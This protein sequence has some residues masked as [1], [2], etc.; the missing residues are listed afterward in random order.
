MMTTGLIK[1]IQTLFNEVIKYSQGIENPI[2]DDVFKNWA[3]NKAHFIEKWGGLRKELPEVV[4]LDR[5]EEDKRIMF[6]DFIFD[7]T[8]FCYEKKDLIK[9]F[10]ED[11]G[12]EGFY[13]NRVIKALDEDGIKIPKGAK[14]SKALKVF[15]DDKVIL[16][17][18]QTRMSRL[19][20]DCKITGKFVMSVHPLDFLS[21]SETAH[22]WHSCHSLD[23]E[24]RTGNLSYM[25][26][27]HTFMFY[28]KAEEDCK[29]PNFP[30]EWNSKKWRMLMYMSKDEQVFVRGRQYPFSN[31]RAVELATDMLKKYYNLDNF[32]EWTDVKSR[33]NNLM[34]DDIG[35][36]QYNDCLCSPSYSPMAIYNKDKEDDTHIRTNKSR[37]RVGEAV[38]CLECGRHMI[39]Y[40][41]SM[42]CDECAGY[43]Y[44]ECCGEACY[45]D[46]MYSLDGDMLCEFCFDEQS[47]YCERCD[48][49]YNQYTTDM[50]W[51]EEDDCCYCP[52]CMAEIEGERAKEREE[53]PEYIADFL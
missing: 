42:C 48:E 32:T 33:I 50:V 34:F 40:S 28:L 45:E 3:K 44:C 49:T 30:F 24:Y 46:D 53:Y 21:S 22:N 6:L 43:T 7:A 8:I 23:G 41:S 27:E 9:R 38:E 25:G 14:L 20:Q 16:D 31:D 18:V 51:D 52:S 13:S 11:Q 4:T 5:P 39:S 26:D 37:M 29:L 17:K 12:V 47:V 35:S 10:L 15:Y 1:D 36:L 2:T 19:I